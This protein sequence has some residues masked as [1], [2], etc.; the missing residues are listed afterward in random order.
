MPIPK[1]LEDEESYSLLILNI[2]QHIDEQKA[3]NQG[4]GVVKPFSVTI[5]DMSDVG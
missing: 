4:K 2:H 3:K 1:L 5:I